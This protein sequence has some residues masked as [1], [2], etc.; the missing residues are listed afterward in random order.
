MA[1]DVRTAKSTAGVKEFEAVYDRP[2]CIVLDSAYCSMG[3]MI[4][5]KACQIAGYEYYDAVE[6]SDK[7]WYDFSADYT[8]HLDVRG[9]LPTWTLHTGFRCHKRDVASYLYPYYRRQVLSSRELT[10]AVERH[11]VMHRG[12][13]TL[14]VGGGFQWGSGDP[15][16]DGTFVTPSE[17]QETAATMDAFMWQDYHLFTAPQYYLNFGLKYAF[18]FPGTRLL[19]HVRGTF[20]YR[21]AN[22]IKNEYCGRD[23]TSASVAIG[24]TF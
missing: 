22:N 17:K 15:Y 19:T 14:A 6:T 2:H 24:C 3:R 9:E 18:R 20:D 11:I 16:V 12:V 7:H 4:G 21:K 13:W 10:A 23:R 5:F 8:L 1:E